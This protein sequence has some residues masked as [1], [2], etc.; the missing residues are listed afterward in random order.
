MN[1]DLA[2]IRTVAAQVIASQKTLE[3]KLRT[4]E[5]SAAE[6]HRRAELALNAGDE[7]LARGALKR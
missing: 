7:E 5:Q 1:A 4:A 3:L 2:K 6:W